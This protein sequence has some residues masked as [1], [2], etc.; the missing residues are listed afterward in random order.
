[1]IRMDM[2]VS[3][4]QEVCGLEHS[5]KRYLLELAACL[6]IG[7]GL[8]AL[9]FYTGTIF[10]I[11]LSPFIPLPFIY[12]HA[13]TNMSLSAAGVIAF[14]LLVY[15]MSNERYAITFL[16]CTLLIAFVCGYVIRRSTTFYF[17]ALAGCGAM[18]AALGVLLLCIWFLWGTSL[19]GLIFNKIEA[20]LYSLPP[21][22]TKLLYHYTGV[23]QGGGVVDLLNFDMSTLSGISTDTAVQGMIRYLHP[24]IVIL[25][26]QACTSVIALFGLLGYIIPRAAVKKAGQ[27]VGPVPVFSKWSLP[28][29]FGTWSI[30]LLLV[31]MVGNF[32]GWNNFDIV[33]SIVMG[34]LNVI[35][36]IQGM[37]FIDWL[38]KKKINVTAGRVAIIAV[39]YIIFSA[40]NM[41]MWLGLFEQVVKL[42]KRE[43][44]SA[45]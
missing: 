45:S 10:L 23:S 18:L 20:E 4:Y 15:V 37:A 16:C 1:M 12:L 9:G 34:L 33:Y 13:R 40:I 5:K 32:A 19:N 36:S 38:L 24:Y 41:Y 14:G 26:P 8:F 43:E 17:S 42:R 31:A 11:I 29:H 30:V 44:T 28:N 7:A 6:G 22:I 39:T 2:S 27:P 3:L 21:D 25:V 35:Y